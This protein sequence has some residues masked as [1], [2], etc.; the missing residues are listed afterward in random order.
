MD[1]ISVIAPVALTETVAVRSDDWR[2]PVNEHARLRT[3]LM[4]RSFLRGFDRNAIEDFLI[5]CPD[6]DRAAIGGVMEEER[7]GERVSIVAESEFFANC[8]LRGLA[9]E[10][11]GGWQI[12]QLIKLAFARISPTDYYLTLDSDIVQFRSAGLADLFPED[13]KALAG[14]ESA[15]DYDR[16]YTDEFSP[17][18]QD[19]KHHYYN[20]SQAILGYDR[21]VSRSGIFFSETPVVLN[22][23][24]AVEMIRYIEARHQ[25]DFAAVLSANRGW[26]EYSLYFQFL[27]MTG[28]LDK[29]YRAGDCNAVLSLEKSVWQPNI[30]YRAQ[31]FYDRLHFRSSPLVREGPFLAIQSWIRTPDWLPSKFRGVAQFYEHLESWLTSPVNP[32]PG[33]DAPASGALD[34]GNH[35]AFRISKLSIPLP[36][37]IAAHARYWRARSKSDIAFHPRH[38][39][40][41][42]IPDHR[43]DHA[44]RLRWLL[45][46][47]PGHP[48]L[49][50]R[51]PR[52]RG[53]S[54]GR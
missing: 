32:S 7:A 49:P 15:A 40:G 46:H 47:H 39:P 27:E 8:G 44:R 2:E 11:W 3:R 29:L 16:L 17:K 54:A 52:R 45:L 28:A 30:C 53:N 25:Q 33:P 13:G 12:Q 19:A 14:L 37:S 5:V 42:R 10:G 24:A 9:L 1:K 41:R 31:R 48:A 21:P 43:H 51:D 35:A 4:L 50:P 26:T 38:L 34:L 20:S 36:R 6:R 22:K 18:E 23:P